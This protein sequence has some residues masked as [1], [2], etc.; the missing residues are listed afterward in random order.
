MKMKKIKN[1][2][3]VTGLFVISFFAIG[4]SNAEDL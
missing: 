3:L 4:I 1:S 2:L